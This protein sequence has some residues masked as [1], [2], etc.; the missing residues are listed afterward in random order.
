M[1]NTWEVGTFYVQPHGNNGQWTQPGGPNTQVFP[2]QATGVDYFSV[3]PFSELTGYQV[4]GCGHYQNCPTLQQEYDED[5]DQ[6]VILVICSLCSYIQYG[7]PVAQV[8]STVYNP[9]TII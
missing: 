3:H 9:V 2:A 8:L 6:L 4:A 5:T 1:A 7:L